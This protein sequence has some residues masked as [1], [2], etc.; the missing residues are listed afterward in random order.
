MKRYIPTIATCLLL[1]AVLALSP[2]CWSATPSKAQS[3]SIK[4]DI[5]NV[6]SGGAAFCSLLQNYTNLPPTEFALI[7]TSLATLASATECNVISQ[8]MTNETGGDES[9][10]QA[11]TGP[12]TPITT[13]LA[14][15]GG[16]AGLDSALG[17]GSS[18]VKKL[19]Q[20]VKAVD[21]N[22]PDGNCAPPE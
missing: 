3:A 9:N 14:Y 21:P 15:G 16:A 8:A 4:A 2:G 11:A 7:V 6:N 22:C 10:S 12:T 18:A 13:D 5:I 17:I 20:P 19:A 1:A